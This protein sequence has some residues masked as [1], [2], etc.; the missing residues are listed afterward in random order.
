MSDMNVTHRP[1][2]TDDEV[3]LI[4]TSFQLEYPGP[5]GTIISSQ[6]ISGEYN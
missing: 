4:S 3:K 5:G 6:Q 2:L 1:A